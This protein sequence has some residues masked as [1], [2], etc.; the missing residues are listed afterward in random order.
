[1]VE[2]CPDKTEVDGSIP[3]TLTKMEE[4]KNDLNTKG[5]WWKPGMQILSEVSTWI[6][7]PIVLA[8]IFGKML[9][10]YYGTRP[11]IFLVFTGVGFLVTCFGIWRVMKNYMQKLKNAENKDSQKN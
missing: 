2:R 11:V 4:E 3:S 5:P 8:L 7:V 6:V 10:A 1:M 9:D